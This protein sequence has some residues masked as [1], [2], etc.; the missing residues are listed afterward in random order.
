MVVITK[1]IFAHSHFSAIWIMGVVR[2]ETGWQG[3]GGGRKTEACGRERMCQREKTGL[4]LQEGLF[5]KHSAN[6][7]L[8]KHSYLGI[9]TSLLVV[10]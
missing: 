8:F 1:W 10:L 7:S 2:W 9:H 5:R 4:C 3:Q 6:S